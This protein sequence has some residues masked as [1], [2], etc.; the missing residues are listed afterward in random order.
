M[1]SLDDHDSDTKKLRP[2]YVILYKK[3]VDVTKWSRYHP[4]GT[5]VLRIFE[6][7]DATM[8]FEAAHSQEAKKKLKVMLDNSE[9]VK[10]KEWHG[11]VPEQSKQDVLYCI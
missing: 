4:G 2:Q 10:E 9:E 7:R 3:R 11:M 5:K 6:N 1:A 8:Q